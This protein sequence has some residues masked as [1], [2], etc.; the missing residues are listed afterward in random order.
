MLAPR[1]QI[2][3]FGSFYKFISKALGSDTMLIHTTLGEIM[4]IVD[5]SNDQNLDICILNTKYK[6]QTFGHFSK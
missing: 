5:K 2:S 1:I 3:N 4:K 6:S